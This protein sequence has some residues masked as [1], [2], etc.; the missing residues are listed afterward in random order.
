M[1][2]GKIL[3]HVGGPKTGTT[4]LQIALSENRQTLR[5][6]GILYPG[7]KWHHANALYPI[8]KINGFESFV[9]DDAEAWKSWCS[10]IQQWA[11]NVVISSEVL[12]FMPNEVI[13]QIISDFGRSQVEILITARSTYELVISQWQESI[14]AGDTISLR[15]FSEALTLGPDD[16]KSSSYSFWQIA[17]YAQPIQR[18]SSKVGIEN[19]T[20]QCV[21]VTNADATFRHFEQIAEIPSGILRPGRTDIVNWSLSY[22]E[23][24]LLR[25]CN[26]LLLDGR[27]SNHLYN[28][29]KPN[30][31]NEIVL[32]LAP[33]DDPRIE[34]P[35]SYYDLL[36]PFVDVEIRRTLNSGARIVGD[37]LL[38]TRMPQTSGDSRS[39]QVK[40]D[41]DLVR[42]VLENYLPPSNN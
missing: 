13:D 38:L 32:R 41:L 7:D 26:Q 22:S 12:L 23:A 42:I 11:G 3:I 16:A 35:A 27:D 34:L 25:M 2:R 4:A 19:V 5:S 14:K 24:E 8:R 30:L 39:S 31:I 1:S 37:P 33:V 20:V 36:T 18:W 29:L 15:E 9:D 21:D 17:N 10:E 40:I 28:T 6:Q